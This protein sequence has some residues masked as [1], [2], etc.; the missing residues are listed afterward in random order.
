[1]GNVFYK[2]GG[3]WVL[4]LNDKGKWEQETQLLKNGACH[5][6]GPIF[7]ARHQAAGTLRPP[8]VH[9]MNKYMWRGHRNRYIWVLRPEVKILHMLKKK[10]K[11]S[12]HVNAISII[13]EAEPQERG[14]ERRKAPS[15]LG[16]A[17]LFFSHCHCEQRI[18]G[19]RQ[20][21]ATC[22]SCKP[23]AQLIGSP[24]LLSIRSWA[25]RD[26]TNQVAHLIWCLRT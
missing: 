20:P 25:G 26:E 4:V 1:M 12:A 19:K 18:S 8:G 23:L 9:R 21:P 11:D 10:K 7:R 15:T 22:L 16:S 17:G 2:G 5:L 24:H 13:Y 3:C 6:R 14:L